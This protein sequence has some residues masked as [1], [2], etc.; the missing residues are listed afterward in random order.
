MPKVVREGQTKSTPNLKTQKPVN[1]NAVLTLKRKYVQ[2]KETS[3][4][5]NTNF[6][7]L[8]ETD[9]DSPSTNLTNITRNIHPDTPSVN[10]V[11][12]KPKKVCRPRKSCKRSLNF[13]TSS[14]VGDRES[15]CGLASEI[16]LKSRAQDSYTEIQSSMQL[17]HE[18]EATVWKGQVEQTADVQSGST[19]G[20]IALFYQT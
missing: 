7:D 18:P 2:R 4:A 5:P 15:S 11:S 1:P 20:N 9:E 10:S 13:D 14:Q 8:T 12:S 3:I 6:V 16:H 19:R 17:R